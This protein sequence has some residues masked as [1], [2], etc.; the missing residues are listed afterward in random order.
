M[1]AASFLNQQTRKIQSGRFHSKTFNMALKSL[2]LFFLGYSTVKVPQKCNLNEKRLLRLQIFK[3][4]LLRKPPN[5]IYNLSIYEKVPSLGDKRKNPDRLRNN[6]HNF[7]I[8]YVEKRT[9]FSFFIH[10]KIVFSFK[11]THQVFAQN[12]QQL[13]C[14]IFMATFHK[15]NLEKL[16]F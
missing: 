4:H 7:F 12:F 3:R 2:K 16:N 6:I 11:K 8:F 1:N 9:F 10:K 13:N 5:H 15:Q 14:K